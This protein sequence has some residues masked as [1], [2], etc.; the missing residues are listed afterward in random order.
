MIKEL[1]DLT[2]YKSFVDRVMDND[3]YADPF[4]LDEEGINSFYNPQNKENKRCLGVFEN[5][6]II[7]IFFLYVIDAE[8]YIEFTRVVAD[9][10]KAYAEIFDFLQ[11]EYKNY[12]TYFIFNPKNDYI[13]KYLNKHNAIFD[14]EQQ[15]MILY[16]HHAYNGHHHITL[17]RD[18]Y[19]DSYMAIHRSDLYW[20]ADKVL[21]SLDKFRVILCIKD[22]KVVGYADVTYGDKKNMPFDVFVCGEYRSQG[23]AKEMLSYAIKLNGDNGMELDVNIDNI[24][25]IKAYTDLGFKPIKGNTITAHFII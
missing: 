12:S 5:R 9:N 18:E 2:I 16:K 22:D 20:T 10:E 14:V 6:T 19:K 23:I 7:G 8:N 17:Y 11:K 1:N 25:A 4:M 3:K 21:N 13:I 24:P 15:K